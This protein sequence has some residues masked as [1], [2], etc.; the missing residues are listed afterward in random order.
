VRNGGV[1]F[2]PIGPNAAHLS[3]D[4]Q[5]L[6]RE[7]TPWQTPWMERV[8]GTLIGDGFDSQRVLCRI[9]GEKYARPSR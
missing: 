9:L 7:D 1:R 8:L 5:R 3:V 4:M 6:F 2:G